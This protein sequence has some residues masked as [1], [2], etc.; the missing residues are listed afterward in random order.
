HRGD[1]P[2]MR[3]F[4]DEQREHRLV[5]AV[6]AVEV[7]DGEGTAPGEVGVAK[8]A[9]DTHRPIMLARASGLVGPGR[10]ATAPS[11]RRGAAASEPDGAGDADRPGAARRGLE[12]A[13]IALVDDH[14]AGVAA[15]E[16]VVDAGEPV[17]AER[18]ESCAVSGVDRGDRIAGGR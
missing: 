16:Q 8:A 15:A 3:G 1:E 18:A 7:A 17:E 2:A 13:R 12:V 6:D 10:R 11:G 14:R 4:G 9:K 5:A